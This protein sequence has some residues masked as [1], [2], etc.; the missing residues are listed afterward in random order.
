VLTSL[1]GLVL[2]AA[3]V[4]MALAG[5]VAAARLLGV[6]AFGIY[7]TVLAATTVCGLLAGAG[8]PLCSVRFLSVYTERADWA[9]HR[10]FLRT[11]L[12]LT[13]ASSVATMAAL[14]ALFAALPGLRG[15]LGA[16]VAGALLVPLLSLTA[17]AISILLS[18]QM[19]LRAE[20]LGNV[21]RQA[22]MLAMLGT[23]MLLG[24]RVDAVG[25][26]WLTVLASAL[27]LSLMAAA[28][29]PML[30]RHWQGPV[31]TA[32][33]GAWLASGGA[34][35]V[36]TAA[37]ALVERVDTILVSALL[38]PAEAGPYAASSRLALL[39]GVAL[40]PVN[41]L[42]GSMGARFLARGDR[43]GLQRVM[44]Q[45][46][47]IS[48]GLG[49][50]LAGGLVVLGP[51]LLA[52]FGAGFSGGVAALAVLAA[53]Q[54]A[55]ALAGPAGGLLA[56]AGHNRHLVAAMLACVAVDIVLCLALIPSIGPAGAAIATAVSLTLNSIAL[57]VMARRLLGVDTTLAAGIM[58]L[59]QRGRGKP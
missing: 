38:S 57:S 20:A 55:V 30:A 47:L 56:M 11:A 49:L 8:M 22:L 51:F 29:L 26:V 37:Y 18:R 12:W 41:A 1:F 9:Q 7:A 54:A 59:L 3:G 23:A 14:L 16:M 25:V 32:E 40:A 4:V 28:L 13:V 48:S 34:F 6:E 52:L 31:V 43:A 10:G 44:G 36:T 42:L 58:L 39:V 27:A 2:K 45:G 33:R 15:M 50:L 24:L 5:Q 19:P 17:L 35:L 53:G 21:S 46:A